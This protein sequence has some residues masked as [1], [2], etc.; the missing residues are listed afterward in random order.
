MKNITQIYNPNN[1]NTEVEFNT[2]I[3]FNDLNTVP[4]GSIENA[5]C[6]ILDTIEISK[7]ISI[8]NEIMKKIMI[9]GSI[10]IKILNVILLCKKILKGDLSIEDIN[11]IVHNTASVVDQEHIDQWISQNSNYIVDKI[12]I[13]SIYTTIVMKRVK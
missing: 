8:Q 11:Y 7:R 10:Q 9:G 12:D 1:K 13:E 6:D 5:Y 4:N 2:K 3:S